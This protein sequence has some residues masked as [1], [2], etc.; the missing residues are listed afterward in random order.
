MRSFLKNLMA[1]ERGV[2]SIEYG[3]IVMAIALSIMAV[4]FLTGTNLEGLMMTLSSTLEH[5]ASDVGKNE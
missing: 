2:T 5:A 3:L 4:L 1:D